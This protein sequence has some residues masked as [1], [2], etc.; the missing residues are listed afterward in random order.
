L[1]EKRKSNGNNGIEIVQC[2]KEGRLEDIL[3]TND[4]IIPYNI[5]KL[6]MNKIIKHDK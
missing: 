3:Y 1:S 5:C 4:Q 6:D 2:E